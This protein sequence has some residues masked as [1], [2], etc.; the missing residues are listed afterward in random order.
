MNVD[1]FGRFSRIGLSSRPKRG[2]AGAQGPPG[3]GFKLTSTGDFDLNGKL[4]QNLNMPSH[5]NDA[6][7]KLYV[8]S[9]IEE[10]KKSQKKE[11]SE[12]A[13]YIHGEVEKIEK[14]LSNQIKPKKVVAPP[15]KIKD[16]L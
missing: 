16:E 7:N 10:I 2:P 9:K 14:N 1:K 15:W 6:S 5:D 8:D 12:L 3:I 13:L 11:F 4:I